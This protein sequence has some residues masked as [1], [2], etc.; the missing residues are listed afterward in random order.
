MKI[1]ITDGLANDAV[2]KMKEFAQVD[3]QFYP[4]ETLGEA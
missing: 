3:M 2:E 4:E 1:L